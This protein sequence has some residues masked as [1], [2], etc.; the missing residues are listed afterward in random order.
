MG[1]LWRLVIDVG[2]TFCY[3]VIAVSCVGGW[4]L[5]G[6]ATREQVLR[7]LLEVKIALAFGA[8]EIVDRSKNLQGLASCGLLPSDIPEI[9]RSL[10]PD[11]YSEGP[12]PDKRGGDVAWWVF[13]VDYEGT[14]LYVKLGLAEGRRIRIMSLHPAERP[15]QYPFRKKT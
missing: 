9:I 1:E 2:S 12:L 14:E 10:T 6:C 5:S 13:G 15:L 8:L 7:F 3:H 11:N 4:R